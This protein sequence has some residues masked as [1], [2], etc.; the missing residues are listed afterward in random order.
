MTDQKELKQADRTRILIADDE[1]QICNM[2]KI[3]FG[4]EFK[5]CRI[6]IAVNGREAVEN[7]RSAHEA[8][9]VMD[10]RMPVMNG[11]EA[12]EEIMKICAEENWAEPV[13]IFCTG[14]DPDKR[15]ARILEDKPEHCL[16]RKPVPT[17]KLMDLIRPHVN[18][19][20]E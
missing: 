10:L 8:V 18:C 5:G 4:S 20:A 11:F 2:F 16:L 19:Q 6:D 3:L 12:Y 15:M 9:I 1:H 14:Y 17:S 7:F 13:V